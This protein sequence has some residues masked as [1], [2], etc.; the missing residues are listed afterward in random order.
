VKEIHL[1]TLAFADISTA[2]MVAIFICENAPLAK[3]KHRVSNCLR[4]TER[5]LMLSGPKG[6][7]Y[8]A[9]VIDNGPTQQTF[10]EH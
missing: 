2:L 5:L 1:F 9:N 7:E 10:F 8:P 4:W 6:P 3:A